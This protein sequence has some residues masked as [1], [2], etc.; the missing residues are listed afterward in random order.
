MSGIA[1]A[2]F[3]VLGLSVIYAG[4]EI[5]D[6]VVGQ[7]RQ[8]NGS[9]GKKRTTKIEDA[10]R[11]VGIVLLLAF[12]LDVLFRGGELLWSLVGALI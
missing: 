5:V 9:Y 2:A 6:S 11:V 7:P 4:A 1:L 3:G 12:V 10:L 8:A